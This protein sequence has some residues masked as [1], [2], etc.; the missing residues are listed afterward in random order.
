VRGQAIERTET[1]RAVALALFEP[2]AVFDVCEQRRQPDV[3]RD[4]GVEHDRRDLIVTLRGIGSPGREI[5]AGVA[6]AGDV[7]RQ[8]GGRV[9]LRVVAAVRER[10]AQ[11]DPVDQRRLDRRHHRRRT[12]RGIA[13]HRTL[14]EYFG[15]IVGRTDQPR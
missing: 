2:R 13:T 15:A 6:L 1:E 3:A 4:R 5:D 14:H 10:R 12:G 9:Q 7:D 11:R 8:P